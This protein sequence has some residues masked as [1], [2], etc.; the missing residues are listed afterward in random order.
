ME[1]LL[2]EYWTDAD[3]WE[4]GSN[5]KSLGIKLDLPTEI[6]S[7]LPP[8]SDLSLDEPIHMPQ[9]TEN[10]VTVDHDLSGGVISPLYPENGD[11]VEGIT[12]SSTKEN[13]YRTTCEE[14]DDEEVYPEKLPSTILLKMTLKDTLK[15]LLTNDKT[16]KTF[17]TDYFSPREE[18]KEAKPEVEVPEHPSLPNE[19]SSFLEEKYSDHDEPSDDE[20][21]SWDWDAES[22]A[23]EEE[24]SNCETIN[25]EA[26]EEEEEYSSEDETVNSNST[27]T[28]SPA[29]QE[30]KQRMED[31]LP[32]TIRRSLG[33]P[34]IPETK[35][36]ANSPTTETTS[37]RDTIQALLQKEKLGG[38]QKERLRL[39]NEELA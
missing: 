8:I 23:S 15:P 27:Y 10:M 21:T 9:L 32:D 22:Y 33:L 1:S 19:T 5:S 30:A 3:P 16:P 12:L 31:T 35:P 29:T 24:L 20:P 11:A 4:T 7:L 14:V 37:L 17:I 25:N 28:I 38:H 18:I 34:D 6:P 39:M 36:T 2:N 26:S 13:P